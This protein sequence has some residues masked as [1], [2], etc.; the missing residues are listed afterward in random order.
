MTPDAWSDPSTETMTGS[1]AL[2]T[3][4]GLGCPM[5]AESIHALLDNVDGVADSSVN[6]A[7]GIVDVRFDSGAVVS[8]SALAA[9]VSG[10]GFSLRAIEPKD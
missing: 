4:E 3:V 8:R 9:A 7:N 6:L 2:L 1:G 10:S 5:C